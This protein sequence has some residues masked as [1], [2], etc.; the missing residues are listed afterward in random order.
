MYAQTRECWRTKLLLVLLLSSSGIGKYTARAT[1]LAKMASRI[2]TSKGLKM[3]H[4]KLT[5]I[6]YDVDIPIIDKLNGTQ[7]HTHINLQLC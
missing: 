4:R 1:Q 6:P 7:L 5:S 2:M 3:I